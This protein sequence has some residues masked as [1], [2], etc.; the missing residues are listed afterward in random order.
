MIPRNQ[1]A[2][3]LLLSISILVAPALGQQTSPPAKAAADAHHDFDFELG[4][5]H[6]HLTRL[7]HPLT[8]STTWLTYDGTS[9]IRPLMD[10]RANLVE[11][12][13]KGPAG[14]IE[15]ISL[16]LYNPQSRQW[17][18][19]FASI[20]GG[21]LGTPTVGE[22]KNGRGE[23]YDQ[24]EFNSRMILVRNIFTDIQPDSYRFEQS[25]SADGGKTWELNWI[26]VDTRIKDDAK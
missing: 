5:W 23:F 6:T 17:S 19:N 22:F 18:L 15:G 20:R 3:R 7:D 10:G 14:T 24:E 1:L 9:F 11:L 12:S 16:R 2:L 26:A 21:T 8:G 25:F 4:T 13:V